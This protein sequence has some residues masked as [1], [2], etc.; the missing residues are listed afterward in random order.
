MI[1]YRVVK[2]KQPTCFFSDYRFPLVQI[3]FCVEV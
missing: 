2:W 3:A 1:D